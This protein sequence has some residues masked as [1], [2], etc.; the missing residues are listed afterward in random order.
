[1]LLDVVRERVRR[2]RESGRAVAPET[3]AMLDE[4]EREAR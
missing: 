3:L 2:G 4:L 1:V